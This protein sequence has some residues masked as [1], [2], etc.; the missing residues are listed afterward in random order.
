MV[1]INYKYI[2]LGMNGC[3]MW[4]GSFNVLLLDQSAQFALHGPAQL[5]LL[6]PH[7]LPLGHLH[8]RDHSSNLVKQRPFHLAS[9]LAEHPQ[10]AAVHLGDCVLLEEGVEVHGDAEAVVVGLEVVHHLQ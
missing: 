2:D 10:D 3:C 4:M 6:G 1:L 5:L 7:D 8:L 9:L